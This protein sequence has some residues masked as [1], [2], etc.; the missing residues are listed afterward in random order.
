MVII[1]DN[2]AARGIV[3]GGATQ[4]TP[5]DLVTCDISVGGEFRYSDEDTFEKISKEL[6][7]QP[8]T[9]VVVRTA[10][11]VTVPD[12]VFGVV[13]SKGS[14]AAAGLVVANTKID[15][16]FDDHLLVP[17]FNSGASAVKLTPG[18][19]FASLYFIDLERKSF[20]V[21]QRKVYFPTKGK[22]P[23]WYFFRKHGVQIFIAAITLV[24]GCAGQTVGEI[25]KQSFAAPSDSSV[26][27]SGSLQGGK[28]AQQDVAPSPQ[29]DGGGVR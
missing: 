3:V 15:P 6:V 7:L 8:K 12:G 25:I 11:R 16:M 29:P 20:A 9:A 28:D 27:R 19:A 5:A 14:L 17:V 1:R 21:V 4:A 13:C 26:N 10:E 22:R 2:F 23:R 24:A 18:M